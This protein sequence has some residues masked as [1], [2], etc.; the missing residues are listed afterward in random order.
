MQNRSA[1]LGFG[2]RAQKHA[3]LCSGNRPQE[4][5]DDHVRF[6]ASAKELQLPCT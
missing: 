2:H 3:A 1:C 4:Q 5:R 6:W